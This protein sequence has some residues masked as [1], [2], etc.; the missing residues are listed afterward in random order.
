MGYSPNGRQESDTAER[1]STSP[2]LLIL[3][4]SLTMHTPSLTMHTPI[5]PDARPVLLMHTPLISA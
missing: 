1:L 2:S 3:T 5:T 4:L